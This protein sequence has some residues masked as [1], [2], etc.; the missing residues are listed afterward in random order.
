MFG[1]VAP[2]VPLRAA[3]V[4]LQEVV[5]PSTV[6]LKDGH[7]LAFAVHG[8]VNFNSLAELF[9][10]IEAQTHRWNLPEDQRRQ[11][12]RRL[13]HGGIESRV[14]SM[15]DERPLEAVITHTAE[16][17][18]QALARVKEPVP[19]GYA[20]EFLAV[21]DKW[22]H[23][24]NAWSAASSIP[25]RVLS[26]WYPIEEGIQLYGA[27][28]DSI[29][30]FWQAIKYHPDMTVAALNESLS[31]LDHRDWSAW[32]AQRDADFQFYLPNAYALEFLRYNLTPERRRWFRDE[33][34]RQKL[35]PADR[36]RQAQ[37]RGAVP[38]RYTAYEEKVLWGDL[39]DVF[40]LI[41]T[42]SPADDPIR[43]EL[44]ARH[45]DGIYLQGRK[46][47]FISEEF[48]GLMLEVWKVKY[49]QI[50]RFGEVIRS[51]PMEIRL[52]HF[53]NDADSPDIPIPVY[54]GYLNQ[55]RD[56]ARARR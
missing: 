22:K 28:Y 45:F 10:Y 4:T 11:L 17:L 1:V 26:C 13:L 20:R 41:Y 46:L 42:F 7:P 2:P 31:L 55:I 29:E 50:P 12:A 54:V 51:V 19:E 40:H 23:S 52:E 30:H 34:D 25:A 24:M 21:Q 8:V 53:L 43:Q 35:A 16:E 38:L 27:P 48:R 15:V 37:Q 33:L 9:P 47:G 36:V 14:V 39:A 6:I 5:T 44:A 32:L 49:L 18:Q 3:D 56:L